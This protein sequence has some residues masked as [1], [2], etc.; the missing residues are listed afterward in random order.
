[1]FTNPEGRN[2]T[3][4]QAMDL[5]D[6]YFGSR[7][8]GYFSSRIAS[9]ISSAGTLQADTTEGMGVIGPPLAV[10]RLCDS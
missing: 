2:L 9:L 5:D 10:Q 7:P 4:A 3:P 8:L 1:V 6:N